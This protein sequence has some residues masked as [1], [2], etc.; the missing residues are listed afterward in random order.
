MAAENN[1]ESSPAQIQEGDQDPELK[2]LC[3]QL[4]SLIKQL[5]SDRKQEFDTLRGKI[6]E[7]YG[8]KGA[9]TTNLVGLKEILVQLSDAL[10]Q[11]VTEEKIDK[12]V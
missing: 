6:E 8:R 10:K 7:C 3:E 2:S 11:E 4:F 12:G 5:Q 1:Q 9:A